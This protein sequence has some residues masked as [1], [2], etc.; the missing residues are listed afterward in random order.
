MNERA[1]KPA[2]TQRELHKAGVSSSAKYQQLVVGK[3]GKAALLRYELI[4]LFSSW[5]PGALGLLLR[6]K[7]Y[8]RLLGSVGRGVVFGTNVVLRHPHKIRLGDNVVIDDNCVLDAK[9][10]DNRGISVGSGVFIGRNTLV[11]CQNGDITIGDQAN[12]GSNCQVFSASSVKIGSKALVAAYSYFVGGGHVY[13]D[14]DVPIMDQGR[15]AKGLA[16]GD[17]VWIGAGAKILDGVTVGEGVIVAAGAVVN[18]S[19]ADKSI[20]GGVPA[21]LIG[22]R[23]GKR[24]AES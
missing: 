23:T 2:D 12:I 11:Y 4:M 24:A 6:S 18:R 7:L 3:P 19:F 22:E 15:T 21:K 1:T 16:V 14:P 13:D 8:P 9:G 17:N 5:V 20:V 10:T